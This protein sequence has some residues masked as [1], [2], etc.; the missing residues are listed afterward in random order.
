MH[1]VSYIEILRKEYRPITEKNT[2][3]N[4]NGDK[5]IVVEKENRVDVY[6]TTQGS[7]DHCHMYVNTE[8]N[9]S[10]TVHRG[11]CDECR[12]PNPPQTP[13]P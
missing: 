10:G 7:D 13:K 5:V 9:E 6:T 3:G 11:E 4:N 1:G 8:N 12:D 2:Y